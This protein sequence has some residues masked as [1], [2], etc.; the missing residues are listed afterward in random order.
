MALNQGLTKQS[1]P[2]TVSQLL[3]DFLQNA[4][5][6]EAAIAPHCCNTTKSCWDRQ[7]MCLPHISVHRFSR[8]SN[9]LWE[10]HCHL[11]FLNKVEVC[12]FLSWLPVTEPH[13]QQRCCW[14]VSQNTRTWRLKDIIIGTL[15]KQIIL[16]EK[17]KTASS[18]PQD[19]FFVGFP[20]FNKTEEL[21]FFFF[22]EI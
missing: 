19:C 20:K 21:I 11:I 5:D 10:T 1:P 6:A 14:H 7:S 15:S 2:G 16:G 18:V 13:H 4:T 12:V 22:W 8:E 9:F 3:C 17:N